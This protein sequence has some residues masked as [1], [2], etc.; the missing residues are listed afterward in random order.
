MCLGWLCVSDGWVNE[1]SREV[2][3]LRM[4]MESPAGFRM[5]APRSGLPYD[6]RFSALGIPKISRCQISV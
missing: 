6:K 3:E 4:L 1:S 2:A 5:A